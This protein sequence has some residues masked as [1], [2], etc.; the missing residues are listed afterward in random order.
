MSPLVPSRR[1]ALAAVALAAVAAC[2]PPEAPR[3]VRPALPSSGADVVARMHARWQGSWWRT[4]AF[5]QQNTRWTR[6]DRE[7]TST[8]LEWM[9]LPGKLR[10]EFLP[11]PRTGG[12]AGVPVP[13][14]GA[15]YLDGTVTSIVG[16]RAQPAQPQP[17]VLLLLTADVYA[18]PVAETVKQLTTLGIDLTAVRRDTFESRPV[19]VVGAARGDLRAPQF[20]VDEERWIALRV[21]DRAPAPRPGQP[22]QPP[23]EFQLRDVREVAGTL[24]AHEIL[25]LREGRRFF[26]E[27]Y[28][29]VRANEALSPALFDPGQW[30]TARR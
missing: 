30:K 17:N 3:P 4:L 10:I 16:G 29:T 11:A 18:Q 20:W 13:D 23:T 14:A 6:D 24:V 8:W 5:T 1:A 25:F 12:P 2:R 28:T 22:G 21:V 19:W 7:D 27:R 15:L 26:R 9:Q